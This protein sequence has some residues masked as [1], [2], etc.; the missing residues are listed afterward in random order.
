A[1][2]T[3]DDFAYVTESRTPAELRQYL[4]APHNAHLMPL[5]RL[6][7]FLWVRL[8]GTLERLPATLVLASY[9]TYVL[10]MLLVGHLVAWESGRPA[11]G[12]GAMAR[13]G[14]SAVLEPSVRWFGAGVA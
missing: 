8:A 14:V 3:L 12:L 13:L 9:L 6:W 7:T 11:L 2:L 10:A 5:L 4:F 1:Q